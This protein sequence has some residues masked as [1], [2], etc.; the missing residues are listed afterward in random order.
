MIKL[1][2]KDIKILRCLDEIG[3]SNI[4]EISRA[5][6]ISRSTVHYR[7]R[8]Y[9]DAGLIKRSLIEIDP[10]ALGLDITAIIL[11]NAVYE[12]IYAEELGE[13]LSK[14]PG[15]TCVYYVLGGIDYIVICKAKDR[16]DLK[17]ILREISSTEG[18]IRTATHFVASTI[19]EEKRLLVN[20]PEEMLLKLICQNYK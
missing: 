20:Y 10:S 11:V 9:Y 14:I 12:K 2:S 3:N 7:L 15:I 6:K 1:D 5:A 19:K 8:K 4:D 13:K 16:E 17:R 18:V